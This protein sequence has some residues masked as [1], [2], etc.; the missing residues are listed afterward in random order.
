MA[1]KHARPSCHEVCDYFPRIHYNRSD[2][3]HQVLRWAR[4][5]RHL[6]LKG[7]W[8]E[9]L[10]D[11]IHIGL[12]GMAHRDLPQLAEGTPFGLFQRWL[13]LQQHEPFSIMVLL[14]FRLGQY[15]SHWILP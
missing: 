10:Q 7:Y 8:W 13:N 1:R 5:V 11:S 12:Q 6:G 4:L 2:L 15:S 9:V 14:A 3:C